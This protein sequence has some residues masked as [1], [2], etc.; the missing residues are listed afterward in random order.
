MIFSKVNNTTKQQLQRPLHIQEHP[1]VSIIMPARNAEKYITQA[2]DSF[3]NQ[4]YQNKELIIINDASSDNT[5]S[6]IQHYA[7]QH[8]NIILKHH[9]FKRG[10]A[11][12]RNQA[13][14]L[15]QGE[16]IGH[17]DSDDLLHPQAIE[18][19]I[20]TITANKD[21][22]LVYSGYYT[23]DETNKT[24]AKFLPSAYSI[25]N[26]PKLGWQHFGLYKK[27]I[28]IEIGKFNEKLMTC[29]DGDFF[30]RLAQK[31]P[32]RRIPQYLYY[33][34]WHTTNIGHTRPHCTVCPKQPICEYYKV[35]N[36]ENKTP[37]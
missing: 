3:L 37:Y 15:A 18:L 36:T 27:S 4:T 8:Q 13:L 10:I 24:I 32:C 35:W 29:S 16:Y 6:I 31:Y 21:L 12:T 11:K 7:K 1:L 34:R 9:F 5:K 30:M 26:L 17:L 22:A 23:I 2:I 33:Y 25:Q 28:A 14:D 20:R 19:T